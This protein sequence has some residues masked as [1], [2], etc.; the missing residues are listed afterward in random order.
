MTAPRRTSGFNT[1][2]A[3]GSI[4]FSLW[5]LVL[6]T[7]PWLLLLLTL[8]PLAAI[9]AAFALGNR[10]ALLPPPRGHPRNLAYLLLV[11]PLGAAM[12]AQ[13]DYSVRDIP[14]AIGAAGVVA[15]IVTALVVAASARAG[16]DFDLRPHPWR[17][18]ALLLFT[19]FP[20]G[21][22]MVVHWNGMLDG[23]SPDIEPRTVLA[24]TPTAVKQTAW[25]LTL[26]PARA[27]EAARRWRVTRDV[28][29]RAVVGA[30]AC[31]ATHP[32]AFG[33]RYHEVLACEDV[34]R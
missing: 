32:G 29:T 34:R 24:R 13:L 1:I 6:P 12:S 3:I 15:V 28:A 8:G 20:Y 33:I 18:G 21:W 22:G 30:P 10:V 23:A 4:G 9:A 14:A 26:A 7:G 16:P 11:P 19:G 5:S 25:Y 17:I 31:I 2:V 27:G